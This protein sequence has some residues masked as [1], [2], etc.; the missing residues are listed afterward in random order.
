MNKWAPQARVILPVFGLRRHQP[1]QVEEDGCLHW[2]SDRGSHLPA[3]IEVSGAEVLKRFQ[4]LSRM[5]VGEALPAVA[6][7]ASEYGPLS[8]GSKRLRRTRLWTEHVSDLSIEL[9]QLAGAPGDRRIEPVECW[10][11][12]AKYFAF[13]GA[14]ATEFPHVTAQGLHRLQRPIPSPL[15]TGIRVRDWQD[16]IETLQAISRALETSPAESNA[17]RGPALLDDLVATDIAK[18]L[19]ALLKRIISLGGVRPSLGPNEAGLPIQRDFSLTFEVGGLFGLLAAELWMAIGNG[20]DSYAC[21]NCATLFRFNPK[22]ADGGRRNR[23]RPGDP[24]Y[25][26]GC[27][28]KKIRAAHHTKTHRELVAAQRRSQ[29]HLNGAVVQVTENAPGRM[30]DWTSEF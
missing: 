14:A 23:P 1:A 25:C 4:A 24:T 13:I 10:V 17:S 19:R 6:Q 28:P 16:V 22:K 27:Y 11:A 20:E 3:D 29:L 21:A 18:L 7:L 26:D 15:A 5:N 2:L 30:L 9:R 12:I 8:L